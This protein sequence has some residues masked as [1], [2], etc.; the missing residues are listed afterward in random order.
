MWATRL[1]AG[2][3]Q[4]IGGL[5]AVNCLHSIK[6]RFVLLIT[7]AMTIV[8][9]FI[10]YNQIQEA[11]AR[12]NEQLEQQASLLAAAHAEALADD[13]WNLNEA[14][15]ARQLNLLV[16]GEDIISAEVREASGLF[17]V[18][19]SSGYA[20]ESDEDLV[21]TQ[22][23]RHASGKI[24]GEV[25]IYVSDDRIQAENAYLLRSQAWEF[26]IVTLVVILVVTATVTNL[27]RPITRM[28]ETMTKLAEGDLSVP[29]PA[30]KRHDEI[31]EMARALEVFKA[32]AKQVQTTLEKERELNGLQRQFVSMVS[33]EFRTPLAI[34]DG[35]AQ[36]VAKRLEK[37]EPDAIRESQQKV[38]VAVARLTDLMESV[39]STARLEEGRIAFEPDV[40][41]LFDLI[42][43][44]HGSYS[45]LHKNREIVLD[46]DRLP[47]TIIADGKLLRQVISNLLSNAIKYSPGGN[48]VWVNGHLDERNEIVIAIRD[49]GVGIPEAE[50]A[51]LFKRFFRAST[52]AGIAGSG[53]G[54]NLVQH[55]VS[56][57]DGQ[58]DV[59]STE[60]VGSTFKVRLPYSSV[61]EAAA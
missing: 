7:T 30:V 18:A 28:T 20:G 58:I 39:L 40:C 43:E 59:E 37:L 32:N 10:A 53:I 35:T 3:C 61:C 14:A 29:I 52:S 9:A 16:S 31:G 13:I 6:A 50:L 46:I 11:S 55:F 34:I 25:E 54:L 48:R 38:R 36:R 23:I 57:H 26:F 47:K 27:V 51:K 42:T 33:H 22:S 19:S 2:F 56:L 12:L 15:V 17:S 5:S 21:I 1:G 41:F 8:Y 60:G 24:I 4:R 49:E 44:I 45:E